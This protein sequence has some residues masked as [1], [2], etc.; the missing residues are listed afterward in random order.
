MQELAIAG[1]RPVRSDRPWVKWPRVDH[2]SEQALRDALHEQ[3]WTVSWPSRGLPSFE[4]R[5][6]DAFADY[7]G[8]QWAVAVDHGSGALVVA[9]EAMDIGPGDEVIVPVLTWVAVA[10][11][12]LR[13]GALPVLVDVDP[14]T[15]CLSADAVAEAMSVRT[16]AVVVVHLASTVAD[17]DRLLTL[18]SRCGVLLLEDCAQAHG[19][20]WAGRQVGTWGAMGVFSFQTGKVLASGEGGALI[21]DQEKFW[22]RAQMLR[23]DARA[24]RDGRPTDGEM[25]IIESGEVIGAN[26]CMSEF[27]AAI[28]VAKLTHLDEEHAHRERQAHTLEECFAAEGGTFFP[29]HV[30][31][32]VD[33]RSI[34]E[35]GIRFEPG[36]FGA[37]SIETVAAAL[38]AELQRP[39]YPPDVLLNQSLLFR[40]GTKRRFANLW[41]PT[42]RDR[43][44]GRRYPGATTFRATT[45]L[46]HHS[47]L[48]GGEADI[49]DIIMGLEKILAC[50]R[51]LA[52]SAG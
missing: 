27:H 9:L 34:Y 46:L 5:F 23:A 40:P 37:V 12:V 52:D 49:A 41:S 26:Y 35:Y 48:L 20:V 6:A 51:D 32:K 28:L 16:R 22:R 11:A 39:V 31:E 42:A 1:G 4:R 2:A 25:E 50:R 24:Y 17:I 36:T 18:C 19:A 14:L 33:R 3:R 21:T 29:V 47:A 30:P 8:A 43:A 7:T 44:L 13:V 10:T 45:L 38:S 15:G